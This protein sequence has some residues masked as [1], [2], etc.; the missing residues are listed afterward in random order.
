MASQAKKTV[1]LFITPREA[2]RIIEMI[3]GW[4]SDMESDGDKINTDDTALIDYLYRIMDA[5]R[6]GLQ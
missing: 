4:Q 2:D 5:T 6:C 1:T 3:S